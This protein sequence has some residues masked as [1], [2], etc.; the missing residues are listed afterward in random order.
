[1]CSMTCNLIPI[2]S[3]AKAASTRGILLLV[4]KAALVTV[5][6]STESALTSAHV[7]FQ[8]ASEGHCLTLKD[9][10]PHFGVVTTHSLAYFVLAAQQMQSVVGSGEVRWKP[11][12]KAVEMHCAVDVP[13]TLFKR[14]AFIV[15]EGVSAASPDV[16][17]NY[18][19]PE[20]GVFHLF[21]Q[22]VD[23]ARIDSDPKCTEYV[24]HGTGHIKQRYLA[25]YRLQ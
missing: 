8:S 18:K 21:G 12:W 17:L 4:T 23:S 16:T 25:S 3:L 14:F 13:V 24:A 9:A 11:S 19:E 15:F 5:Q 6:N 22:L 2:G 10:C 20:T 1:M 7:Y